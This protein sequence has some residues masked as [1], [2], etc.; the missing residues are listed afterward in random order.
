MAGFRVVPYYALT[1][2][3]RWDE[4]LAEPAPPDNLS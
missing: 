3:G 1:R 4:M 2:F